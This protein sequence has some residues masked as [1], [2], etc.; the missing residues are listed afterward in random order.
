M[1]MYWCSSAEGEKLVKSVEDAYEKVQRIGPN[2]IN[3]QEGNNELI[4]AP[5]E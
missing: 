2:P 5:I 4:S 1:N 3:L